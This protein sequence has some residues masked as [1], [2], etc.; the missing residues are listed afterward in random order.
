ME[1]QR[2][3]IEGFMARYDTKRWKP[4]DLLKRGV[5]R[6]YKDGKNTE[7]D[8]EDCESWN[9][10]KPA[11]KPGGPGPSCMKPGAPLQDIERQTHRVRRVS[12]EAPRKPGPTE[13]PDGKGGV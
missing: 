1:R 10:S 6:G 2:I 13:P 4:Y 12:C 8:F 11:W 7:L 3:R 5:I 9:K